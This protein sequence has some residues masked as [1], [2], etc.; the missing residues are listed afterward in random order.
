[1]VQAVLE[2][3]VAASGQCCR[4]GEIGHVPGG[5]EQ[6]S[7]TADE[8]SQF[9]LQSVVILAVSSDQMGGA[10]S[11][12][13]LLGRLAQRSANA[14]IGGK[15]EIVVAAETKVVPTVNNNFRT[16]GSLEDDPGTIEL[17]LP[18]ALQL[19]VQ[20]LVKLL[21]GAK[22]PHVSPSTCCGARAARA[23]RR[24]VV[25]NAG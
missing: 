22:S 15:A 20:R 3:S 14:V 21:G 9:L 24:S 5:K 19:G 25:R 23:S 2:K 16:L 8:G 13:V 17:L 18:A 12:P 11:D 10:A 7:L 1:M 4:D 6:R